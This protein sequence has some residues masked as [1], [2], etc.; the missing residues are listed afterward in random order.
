MFRHIQKL[1]LAVSLA[2]A[3]CWAQETAEITGRIVDQ[4]GSVVPVAKSNPTAISLGMKRAKDLRP[5]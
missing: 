1:L 2:I 3:S 4:T 5:T